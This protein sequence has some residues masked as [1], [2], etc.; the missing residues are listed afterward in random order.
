M[1]AVLTHGRS[2]SGVG[3]EDVTAGR[4]EAE[5]HGGPALGPARREDASEAGAR[6]DV[7]GVLVAAAAERDVGDGPGKVVVAVASA[8]DAHRGG[9]DEQDRI[10]PA[11]GQPGRAQAQRAG[12]PGA[13]GLDLDGP[14]RAGGGSRDPYR[15]L[16]GQAGEP[17]DERARRVGVDLLWRAVLDQPSRL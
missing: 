5:P 4:V 13:V 8:G 6:G 2:L 16:A 7:D 1:A 15:Q 14:V 12:K 3:R 17:G 11:R 9:P 10:S